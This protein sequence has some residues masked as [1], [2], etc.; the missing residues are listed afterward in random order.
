LRSQQAGQR[1]ARLQP[2]Q[3]TFDQVRKLHGLPPQRVILAQDGGQLIAAVRLTPQA[4]GVA[5]IHHHAQIGLPR[6]HAANHLVT[7]GFFEHDAHV[8]VQVLELRHVRWQELGHGRGV[9]QNAQHSVASRCVVD[10]LGTHVDDACNHLACMLEQVLACRREL[11]AARVPLEQLGLEL[12]LQQG[13]TPTG[14]R[15]GDEASLGSTRQVAQ[16]GRLD[17]QR[18]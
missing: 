4:I 10:H 16:F 11:Q 3:V 5:A 7:P 6:A 17:E 14:R 2:H 13:Q 18:Q 1:A 9:A 12:M 15:H 8:L